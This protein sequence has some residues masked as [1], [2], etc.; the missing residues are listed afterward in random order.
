MMHYFIC[1]L[2]LMSLIQ[3]QAHL[4]YNAPCKT[5]VIFL[6]RLMQKSV[7]LLQMYSIYS[8]S[9]NC[10]NGKRSVMESA[11]DGCAL[12]SSFYHH[13][14]TLLRAQAGHSKILFFFFRRG[15][16]PL[17]FGSS[18]QLLQASSYTWCLCL[19]LSLFLS[20]PE[21]NNNNNPLAKPEKM[22]V[23]L[24]LNLLCEI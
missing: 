15:L 14:C 13:E 24:H 12:L 10:L 16:L 3:P 5:F 2:Y 11:L 7:N 22:C 8:Q 4:A 19:F 17:R 6:L 21:K 23:A 1:V 9:Q 20:L 18:S